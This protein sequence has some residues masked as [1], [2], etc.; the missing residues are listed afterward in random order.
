M[1]GN[2]LKPY[3]DKGGIKAGQKAT[4]AKATPTAMPTSKR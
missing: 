3:E 4:T 1:I 2:A